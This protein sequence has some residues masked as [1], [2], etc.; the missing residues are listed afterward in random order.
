M[1]T[2]ADYVV[3]IGTPE[4]PAELKIVQD[5]ITGYPEGTV[6]VSGAYW[7]V[8]D[9]MSETSHW[10]RPGYDFKFWFND[11]MIADAFREAVKPFTQSTI[12]VAP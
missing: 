1:S 2:E 7:R 3:N 6:R 12:E 11:L 5:F 8:V 4:T 9:S 10:H